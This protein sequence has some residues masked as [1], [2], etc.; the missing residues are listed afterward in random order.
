MSSLPMRPTI[1]SSHR[2][3]AFCVNA[4]VTSDRSLLCTGSSMPSITPWPSTSPKIWITTLDEY[5]SLSRNIA[6]MSSC[7]YTMNTGLPSSPGIADMSIRWIGVSWRCLANSGYGSRT[8]PETTSSNAPK[9]SRSSNRS[10]MLLLSSRRVGDG[11][12]FRVL[13]ETGD[14]VLAADA[15]GLVAA[16]RRV[17]AVAR[18]AVEPD[19]AGTQPLG[20][21]E[22][23]ID[24]A[25]HDVARQPVRAVIGDPH[26]VV[27]VVER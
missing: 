16:E 18:R 9:S 8:L 11:F 17:R 20:H 5:V 21:R 26:G 7:R 13:V 12:H 3:S 6:W 14:S 10:D 15:A 22:R 23:V 4:F 25:G 19:E 1:S 27:L 2:A 24:S